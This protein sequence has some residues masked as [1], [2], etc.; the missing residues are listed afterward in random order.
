VSVKELDFTQLK[1][2]CSKSIFEFNTTDE[3]EPVKGIIGQSRA[4][5]AIKLGLMVKSKGYNIYISGPPGCGKTSYAL[6]SAKSKA[7]TEKPADDWCYVYNFSNPHVPQALHFKAGTGKQFR[8]DINEL[9]EFFSVELQKTFSSADYEKQ[10]SEIIKRFDEKRDA[11]MKK[12]TSLASEHNF[13]VKNS[14]TGFY[15]MPMID[16]VSLSEEKY[17]SLDD[18]A[19]DSINRESTELTNKAS[20]IMY[21]L[22]E[23][24]KKCHK[25]IEDLNYKTGMFA[26]SYHVSTMQEKYKDYDEVLKFIGAI[27][28]DIL[29][30]V[31]KFIPPSS[32]D[33][34]ATGGLLPLINKKSPDDVIS[35]YRVNLIT[36]NSDCDGAPVV[37]DF[38]PTFSNLMGEIEYDNELGNLTT[39][40]MKIKPGLFHKANGG[41]LI[42]QIRDVLSNFQSWDALRRVVRTNQICIECVRD[43]IGGSFPVPSLDPQPIPFNVKII[44]IGTPYYYTLLREYDEDFDKYFKVLAEFDS[45]MKRTDENIK[46]ISAFI[47]TFC[48]QNKLMPFDSSAVAKVVDYSSRMSGRQDRLTTRFNRLGEILC[49]ADAWARIDKKEKV[50]VTYIDKTVREREQRLNLYEEKLS[51]MN[52]DGTILIDTTGSRK[53]QI[54]GLAVMDSGGYQFGVVSRITATSYAGKSGV[55]NIEKESDMSGNYHSKGVHIISGYLGN[56]YAQD[57]PLALSCRICF[58]QNYGG[59]DGDSA[60]STELYCMLSSLSGLPVDQQKAVTGSVNQ[61]GDIQAIGGVNYKIEA[62]FDLCKKRGFTGNQGVLMPASNVRDLMLKD[63]VVEAV[64]EGKFHIY[65]ISHIDEGL[66][67]LLKTPAGKKDENGNFPPE[68]V[69]GLVY[70]KLKDYF[71]KSCTDLPDDERIDYD[72]EN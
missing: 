4:V 54:N 40:F 11:L 26:I 12:M 69:H 63:E 71:L 55:I 34:D 22:R 51:E 47:K 60:S 58:E 59:V 2:E 62:F 10:K 1:K 30:N 8:D 39:D 45:E 16:G 70:K 15:F 42:L 64:K 25:E 57:F 35:K 49:E 21:D 3:I 13:T 18:E 65:P 46:G 32:D 20:S 68:S 14:A 43:Q 6:K 53:G 72:N 48:R 41:Y 37:I 33:D 7:K 66:E 38:N 44:L 24:E 56:M 52:D 29:N 27:Q 28:E 19:K 61:F 9:A 50:D 31:S 17:D 36:D 23:C 67:I 5:K